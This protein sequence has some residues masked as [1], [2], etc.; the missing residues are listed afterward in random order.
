MARRSK[1]RSSARKTESRNPAKAKRTVST[2]T[3]RRKRPSAADLEAQLK[4]RT[5]K[6]ALENS[7]L[8][9]EL[10]QRSNELS[11]SLL[12]QAATSEVL[13][14]IASSITDVEPVFEK[15]LENATRVCG[16][17]F[18]IMGL[19]D[20]EVCISGLRYTMCRSPLPPS[21]RR[22]SAW[23]TTAR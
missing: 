15:L 3:R 14:V 19:F 1:R 8:L 20:G 17:E 18:G 11:E 13:Q 16:A 4:H 9:G 10:R 6:L 21:L 5:D 12:Q 23:T 7:R 2:R 22:K